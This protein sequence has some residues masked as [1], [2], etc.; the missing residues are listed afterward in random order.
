MLLG[1]M[2]LYFIYLF[3]INI[4]FFSWNVW[5]RNHALGFNLLLAGVFMKTDF[6]A[7]ALWLASVS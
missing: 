2:M 4:Y 1:S 6:L 7:F 3:S 5:G